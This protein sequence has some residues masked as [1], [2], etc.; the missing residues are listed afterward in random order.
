MAWKGK[1]LTY[2]PFLSIW[3]LIDYWYITRTVLVSS[4][5]GSWKYNNSC[6]IKV[7]LV[8]KYLQV[9]FDPNLVIEIIFI[10]TFLSHTISHDFQC[11]QWWKTM[12]MYLMVWYQFSKILELK[13]KESIALVS[14]FCYFCLCSGFIAQ[15]QILE[16]H[17]SWLFC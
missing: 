7:S 4:S 2:G 15:A 9:K 5:Q 17:T 8:V 1:P 14:Y 12:K 10:C 6:F 3:L 11:S 13:Q 16:N